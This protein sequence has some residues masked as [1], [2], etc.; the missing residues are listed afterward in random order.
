MENGTWAPMAARVMRGM[1]E[2]PKLTF[3]ENTVT[4]KAGDINEAQMDALVAELVK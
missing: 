4:I 1:L 2:S 3:A